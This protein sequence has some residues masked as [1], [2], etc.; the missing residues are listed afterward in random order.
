MVSHWDN[1]D[2]TVERGYAGA[3]IFFTGG[4]VT[5]DL[6]RVRDYARLLASVGVNAVCLNNVNVTPEAARLLSAPH[7]PRLARL[8]GVLRDY[9]LRL[10]LSV[11]FDSPV[12][13]SGLRSA[14][15]LDPLVGTW[16]QQRAAQVYGWIP[17]LGGFMVKADSE[18]RPGPSS[19]T[20][21]RTGGTAART[22]RVPAT[23]RSCRSTALSTTT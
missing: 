6:C 18:S 12:V 17:D 9:G 16:W 11:S 23:T 13:L 15:P 10:F 2:G 8:A 19:T 21:G 20:A 14:D 1:L 7:L 22:G 4:Q 5:Q 3:S